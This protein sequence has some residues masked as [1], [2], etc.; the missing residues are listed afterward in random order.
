MALTIIGASIDVRVGRG[1]REWWGCGRTSVGQQGMGVLLG[2]GIR[3]GMMIGML[4]GMC[5]CVCVGVCAHV[6]VCVCVCICGWRENK[7]TRSERGMMS[8]T[9]R[10]RMMMMRK[11]RRMM[12]RR[13]GNLG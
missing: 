13:R 1:N 12:L 9:K 4:L 6:C 10:K 7:G 3:M 2:M 11:R 8:M 5:K